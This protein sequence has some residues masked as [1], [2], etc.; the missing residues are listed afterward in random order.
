MPRASKLP[1]SIDLRRRVGPIHYQGDRPTCLAFAVTAAHELHRSTNAVGDEDLSEEALYWG[2]KQIDTTVRG[3]T[4]FKAAR[5]ALRKWGQPIESVWPYDSSLDE[6][7]PYRPP[8]GIKPGEKGWY[9]IGI[10]K[11]RCTVDSVRRELSSGRIVAL[12]VLLTYGFYRP[13]ANWIPAPTAGEGSLGGHAVAIVGY[14]D[15]AGRPKQ[16][17]L[18]VRNS[19]GDSWGDQGYGWLPYS[20]VDQLAK[21]A[22]V[23]AV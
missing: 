20:Y 6:S 15:A 1:I 4:T 14:D 11:V 19:W 22:W 9:R 2:S 21:E 3:G 18:L 8:S 23:T 17:G 5:D 10:R 12:G 16:G 7:D 13:V